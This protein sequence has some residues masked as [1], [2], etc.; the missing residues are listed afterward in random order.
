VDNLGHYT[1]LE[2]IGE[3]GMGQ[4]FR[5][6][7]ER[8][9]REVAVKVLPESFV[10]DPERL[11]RFEREAQVL[12]SLHHPHV[13]S[14]FGLEQHEEIRFLTLE[15]VPGE[16]LARRL[17]KG[18]LPGEDAVHIAAQIATAIEAAH[19]MGIVHRDLKPSNVM[20]TPD[21]EA[22]VLDFGLAK[23]VE[24]EASDSSLNL[25]HSPTLTGLMTE[26][27]VIL[28]TAAYMSPEQARGKKVDKR[29]DIWSFGVILFEMLTG[30]QLF[31]GET[32]SDTL[33]SVLKNEIDFSALPGTTPRRVRGLLER[34][35]TRD[36]RLRLRD[37][38]EARIVL[39]A[40]ETEEA[41]PEAGSAQAASG[42]KPPVLAAV[43][44]AALV[45]GLAAG[46]F[47]LKPGGHGTAPA[48][49]RQ[50]TIYHGPGDDAPSDPVIS[51]DGTRLA[52]LRAGSIWVRD[53][54]RL[55]PRHLEKTE[56]VVD[57]FWSPGS[58]RIGYLT[59]D[60]VMA[61]DPG[62]GEPVVVTATGAN[63]TASTGAR[64]G[65]TSEYGIV[66]TTGHDDL[67][68]VSDRGGNA[69]VLAA[70][71][72]SR[73]IDLHEPVVLPDGSLV[74]IP[75]LRK[76]AG[77]AALELISNGKRTELLPPGVDRIYSPFWS[78]TGHILYEMGGHNPGVWA[79]PFDLASHR[80]TGDPFLVFPHGRYPSVAADGTLS[81]LQGA[82]AGRM[83]VV[84]TDHAGRIVRTIGESNE[85]DFDLDLSPDG[86]RLALVR[87]TDT[88][89]DIWIHDIV[90]GTDS[91]LTFSEGF[92]ND[93]RWS[94]DGA[95][96]SYYLGRSANALE[97]M[98]IN[99]DGSA[100]PESLR[101]GG[102]F[103]TFVPGGTDLVV[104]ML[105][106]GGLDLH[107]IPRERGA[108]ARVIS[109][110][111]DWQYYGVVSPD[112]R[113][114]AYVSR[115]TGSDQIF[116][117]RFPSGA[118]KW[119]VSADGGSWP[120]WTADGRRLLFAQ[121]DAIVE[122]AVDTSDPPVLGV[123][124][125]LF[126]RQGLG[127]TIRFNFFPAFAMTGDA[128]RFYFFQ[129]VVRSNLSTAM[130]VL[131]NWAQEFQAK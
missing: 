66:F 116:L 36:P 56:Q 81:L 28:G 68:R 27:N 5:A 95:Q 85:Y 76:G 99:V 54:D 111:N 16:D 49:P 34:C 35:L 14:I 98:I 37:I 19:E 48:R 42:I 60:R 109:A 24:K 59:R 9:K 80:V 106:D 71:D 89:S 69:V 7:D 26:A 4:V 18:P 50:F 31:E 64:G 12:A 78:P 83:N 87:T 74:V 30:K 100:E 11:A 47:L 79:L 65:W 1:I 97:T 57:L 45:A 6:R 61:V 22:K 90:R 41:G 121:T 102:S 44:I 53:L 40:G 63:V 91:R 127:F 115:E 17:A 52:F 101:A 96:I 72:T 8:L 93:P 33:A 129:P 46:A 108:P 77:P 94:P 55:E 13:A 114:V 117:R 15:L 70:A 62:D 122:V 84:E 113:Y 32:V 23:A 118:G 3:G 131:E 10:Q 105:V 38:G 86:T 103:G 128:D 75:H 58:D 126:E 51:P 125:V 120:H 21:G 82:A 107:L 25:S 104:G 73:E 29:A 88:E 39:G 130:V 124:K 20:L 2:K 43:G 67:F 119:Q 112:G 123:P 92:K 110:D